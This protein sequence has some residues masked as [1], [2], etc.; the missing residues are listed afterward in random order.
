MSNE[1]GPTLIV[2]A[3]TPDA[4]VFILTKHFYILG[5]SPNAGI[6]IDNFYVSRR[7][8]EIIV[9]RGRAWIRDLGSK[10]GT[11]VNGERVGETGRLLRDADRI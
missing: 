8:A 11:F 6:V 4:A 10:N 3:G 2:Q 5:Q 7:H 1:F 9:E